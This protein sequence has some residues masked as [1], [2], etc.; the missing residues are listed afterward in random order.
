VKVGESWS[1]GRGQGVK[2]RGS[3]SGSQGQRVKVRESRSEGQGQRV[4]VRE[5]RLA[6]VESGLETGVG[7]GVEST[8]ELSWG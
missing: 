5:S 1:E 4:K 7:V 8:L 3:R 2:V 6:D